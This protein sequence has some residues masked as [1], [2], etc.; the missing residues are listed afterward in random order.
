VEITARRL[1]EA[2]D[3]FLV[4]PPPI[5]TA[6]TGAAPSFGETLLSTYASV[7]CDTTVSS[8]AKPRWTPEQDDRRRAGGL[9]PG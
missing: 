4:H 5:R 3:D 2:I 8:D 7:G 1:A 9:T 6:P